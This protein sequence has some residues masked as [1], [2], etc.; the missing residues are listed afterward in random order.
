MYG[1][2]RGRDVM[3]YPE[4]AA[5]LHFVFHCLGWPCSVPAVLRELRLC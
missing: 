1:L 5:C 3:V 2:Y 4:T